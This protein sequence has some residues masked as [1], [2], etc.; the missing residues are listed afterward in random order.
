M[1]RTVRV[2]DREQHAFVVI[3]RRTLE[4]ERLSWAARGVI[5][6]LLAKPDD[7]EIR[8]EDFEG[9]ATWV[10]TE[11]MRCSRSLNITAISSEAAVKTLEGTSVTLTPLYSKYLFLIYRLRL[12]RIRSNRTNVLPRLIR[13]R[14]AWAYL[15]MDRNR[16]GAEVGEQEALRQTE[17]RVS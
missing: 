15:G 4:D 5:R 13:L 17:W 10:A 16:F 6:Y 14:D 9:E 2:T 1:G 11:S 8:V 3:D 7:W 12:S